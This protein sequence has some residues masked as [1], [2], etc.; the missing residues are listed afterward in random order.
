MISF[1]ERESFI[2]YDFVIIGAGIVGL[3]TALSIREKN[4]KASIAILEKGILPTGASTKNAGFACFG[5]LTE[6]LTDVRSIGSENTLDLVKT[7]IKGLK[8]LRERVGETNLDF[9]Q[10]GGYELIGK[11]ELNAVDQLDSINELL[12]PIFKSEVFHLKPR[13]IKD[14]GF[15]ENTIKTLVYNPYEGQLDTGKMI[16]YLLVIAAQNGIVIHTGA[17]VISLEESG[18]VIIKAKA[19]N[20]TVSFDASRVIV[21]TNA[22]TKKL[23]PNEELVPGRGVV[24]VTKPIPE[25]RFK[26]TFHIDQGFYYFRDFHNRVIFGG[27]RNAFLEEETSTEFEINENI[28]TILREKLNTTL[29]PNTS[30]SIDT[31]WTGIMA[32]GN[33]RQPIIRWHSDKI[34]VGVRLGGM[35]VAIGSEVGEK[36]ADMAL[37]NDV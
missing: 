20:S 23:I 17:E 24:L 3:A 2:S 13:L 36:L 31:I 7:R 22:F 5:S 28:L 30:Y 9:Q 11:N 25:L 8:R 12:Y 34:L 18:K 6:L 4:P 29:L 27:G 19:H 16:K 14:F 1:W 32:F 35:G 21:C 37:E 10:H 15:D 26:G 33:S